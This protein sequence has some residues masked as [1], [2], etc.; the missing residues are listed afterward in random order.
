MEALRLR[1]IQG[2]LAR[3]GFDGWLIYDFHG[4]NE[5]A[6]NFLELSGVITRRSFYFI[7]A[8]GAPTALVH[9]I[10]KQ[11]FQKLPG[12]AIFYSSYKILEE[13]LGRLLAGKKRVAMEYAFKGRLP[14]IGRV[15]AGT[16][17]LVRSC[18]VEVVSSA[19]LVAR[20]SA[21]LSPEQVL[22]HAEA[23][24]RINTIKDEAFAF[25]KN[26]LE[27]EKLVTE[28]DV[29]RFVMERFD[30]AGLVTDAAPI[31]SVRE[32]GGN[33]HYEPKKDACAEIH[34][35]DLIL[36]DLWAK[37]SKPK[38]VYAD[39]TWMAWAGGDLPDRYGRSFSLI[40]L[41]RDAAVDYMIDSWGRRKIFGYQ[42]DDVC[43]SVIAADGEGDYF[44]HRTGHSIAESVHGTGPNI[45]NLETEDRREL[46][47]GH[48][49][50]IEP[51]LYYSDYGVRT[52]IDVLIDETGPQITTK[53]VQEEIVRLFT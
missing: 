32:N 37:I 10:E 20:F 15:D 46:L 43:R 11:P 22:M 1:E 30:R 9:N 35:D 7:P 24:S 13:E 42:V 41:A 48:L 29:A 36:L 4:G 25:I 51:G 52:E 38:A 53:P 47:P 17:E 33:P 45:D 28:Y 23:S 21:C 19:D 39:I 5:V 31:C 40:C 12:K 8:S 16:I 49:F 3:L 50:S 18:G 44:I 6:V 2:E 14:Y 34:R 26:Q 27:A